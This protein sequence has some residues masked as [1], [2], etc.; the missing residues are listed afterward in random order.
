M[1][2]NQVEILQAVCDAYSSAQFENYVYCLPNSFERKMV[3]FPD[4]FQEFSE[5]FPL[6][7]QEYICV[8]TN[9]FPLMFQEFSESFTERNLAHLLRKTVCVVV[10]CTNSS[11]KGYVALETDETGK[12]VIKPG[13]TDTVQGHNLKEGDICVFCFKDE[14]NTSYCDPSAYLRLVI[15]VLEP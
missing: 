13:W 6:M 12:A 9:Y 7:L 11:Y 8:S 1:N 14:R 2:Y 5:N 3:S 10:N 4:M 15:H